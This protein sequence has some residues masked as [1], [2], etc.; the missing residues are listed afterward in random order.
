MNFLIFAANW[1]NRGDESAVR[2]ML[3]ELQMVYPKAQFKIH[4]G[5]MNVT[6]IPYDN[7]EI[8]PKF[9]NA[10]RRFPIR[11]L[12]YKLSVASYG[13]INMMPKT[14]I[15]SKANNKEALVKFVEAV[16]WC[17]LAI[18]A[19]GGPNIGDLY[20]T[21]T[22][23]DCIDIIRHYNKP[24]VFYAPS[25]GPFKQYKSRIS[26][27]LKNSDRVAFRENISASYARELVPS[28]DAVVTLDSAFQ[29][30]IDENLYNGQMK[31]YV[32]LSEYLNLHKKC[33]G[34]TITDLSWHSLY[35]D[36]KIAE[37]IRAAFTG[38]IRYLRENEYG[39]VFIPQLFE[40]GDDKSYMNSYCIEGCFIVDD[41]HD[42][43][44]QQ[45][46]ISKLYAVVGMRYHSNIF[47]AKMG[48]PFISVAY[49]QK[50]KGFME[51]IDLTE[52]CF[53]IEDLS[54]DQ[55]KI[56][57]RRLEENYALYKKRS[58]ELHSWF[59]KESYRTTEMVISLIE[60]KGLDK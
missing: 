53:G 6:H 56:H 59:Q 24:Y 12:L 55:L 42:C 43:Y 57:F 23:L 17:D 49:E 48:T 15:T 13:K 58:E 41:V 47:S 38:L 39:V 34:I 19:P 45:Y 1:Y 33:V 10:N 51:K 20:R 7:I 16:K 31:T 25:M 5:G 60:E 36:G 44:F 37:K 35:R 3:D 18:Y 32:E 46:L 29:H 21:Y 50:M 52:Y 4:F 28:L 26:R 30:S 2:A 11:R 54:S 27:I 9:S 22:L 8:V 40:N 14:R